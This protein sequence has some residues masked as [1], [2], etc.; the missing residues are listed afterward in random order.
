MLLGVLGVSGQL[1]ASLRSP[2][3]GK[4][5]SGPPSPQ[6]VHDMLLI[7][8]LTGIPGYLLVPG[9]ASLHC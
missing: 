2:L 9:L 6:L 5:T 7:W 1:W 3:D 8:L 4:T